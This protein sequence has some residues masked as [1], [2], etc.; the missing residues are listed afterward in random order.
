M[1]GAM[2]YKY[3]YSP[4]SQAKAIA[5]IAGFI[6]IDVNHNKALNIPACIFHSEDDQVIPYHGGDFNASIPHTVAEIAQKNGC[7]DGDDFFIEDIADDGI[8]VQGILY[9]CE[10]SKRVKF[11]TLSGALHETFM[12]SDYISGPNDMDYF[13]EIWKFFEEVKSSRIVNI[14]SSSVP[15]V[16]PNPAKGNISFYISGNYEIKELTGKTILKGNVTAGETISIDNIP[17]GLYL[18]TL[19]SNEENHVGKLIIM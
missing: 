1:G 9:N 11:Y 17:A 10:E 16:Y 14:Y 2:T 3:A 18:I 6:G 7:T 19:K 8:T 4:N 5:V 13:T 15:I 12:S